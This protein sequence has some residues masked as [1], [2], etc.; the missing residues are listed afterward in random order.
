M[1]IDLLKGE[2]N[3]SEKYAL[4][5]AKSIAMLLRDGHLIRSRTY[6]AG[7]YA[8]VDILTDLQTAM[9]S[10]SLTPRQSES[11]AWVYGHDVTLDAAGTLMGITKQAVRHAVTTATE[12]IAAVFKQWNYSETNGDLLKEGEAI[13]Q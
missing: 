8:G 10:A 5:D 2:R 13:A 1:K 12:K 4:I 7:D 3:Y 9:K 6:Y 11:I